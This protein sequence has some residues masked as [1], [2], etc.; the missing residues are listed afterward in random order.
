[1]TMKRT[2]TFLPAILFCTLMAFAD[3]RTVNFD[4]Q[5]DFSKIK[6]FSVRQAQS[7]DTKPELNNPLFLKRLAEAA[8]AELTAKGLKETSEKPDVIV[9]IRLDST[10][11]SFE[12]R[13]PGTRIP[14]SPGMRGGIVIKATGPENRRYTQGVVALDITTREPRLLIWQGIYR[15]DESNSSKLAQ[16]LPG[17]VKKLLSQ[18]PPKKKK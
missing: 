18:Y 2:M 8:R 6:T 13:N 14:P 17:D 9:D 16:K 5:T 1:M 10:D 12:T 7:M 15:N 11:M 3:E 4:A